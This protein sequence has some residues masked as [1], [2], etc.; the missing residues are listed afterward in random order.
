MPTETQAAPNSK[1][2][3][4]A[5]RILSAIPIAMLLMS[6]VMKLT[7]S[8]QVSESFAHLGWPDRLATGLGI[9]E[10]VCTVLYLVPQTCVLGAILLTGYMGGAI[11]THVRIGEPFFMQFGFGVVIW[12]GLYLRDPRLRALLPLRSKA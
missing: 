8:A 10:I 4:W 11:A 2:M 5:G 9:V 7:K 1:A 3:L 6:G 12:L